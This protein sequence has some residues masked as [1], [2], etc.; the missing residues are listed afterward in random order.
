MAFGLRAAFVML[1]PYSPWS[2]AADYDGLGWKLALGLGYTNSGGEPTAIFPPLYPLALAGIYSLF[3][4]S[5]LAA[6][7]LNIVLDSI[8]AL[9]L[10]FTARELLGDCPP[11][12]RAFPFTCG[13]LYAINPI[14]IYMSGV[15][16]TEVFFSTVLVTLFLLAVRNSRRHLGGSYVVSRV[17]KQIMTFGLSGVFGGLAALTKAN[18]VPVWAFLVYRSTFG[19]RTRKQSQAI[20]IAG[21]LFSLTIAPWVVR[22]WLVSGRAVAFSSHGPGW[23]YCAGTVYQGPFFEPL[24]FSASHESEWDEAEACGQILLQHVITHPIQYL[25]NTV[26]R[27]GHMLDLNIEAFILAF[28]ELTYGQGY[29]RVSGFLKSNPWFTS[30]ALLPMFQSV[31]WVGGGL[32]GLHGRFGLP[33]RVTILATILLWVFSYAVF[34]GYPRYFIPMIPFLTLPLAHLVVCFKDRRLG[35]SAV[36]APPLG[37]VH[38]LSDV[39]ITLTMILAAG[40][41]ITT[42]I[43]L[44]SR[45]Q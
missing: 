18:V 40:T 15:T 44:I 42:G 12:N 35:T 26:R 19:W 2:D 27:A 22:N 3:G 24:P 1:V 30:M 17:R 16:M 13:L 10:Y 6:R 36:A 45:V 33:Y 8:T 39:T 29:S 21:L 28:S 25:W 20:V 9:I 37:F 32:V 34:T 23:A 38:K 41:W 14:T 43:A 31:I 5:V 7:F 4:H 11:S